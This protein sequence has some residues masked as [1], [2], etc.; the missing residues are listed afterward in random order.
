[1]SINPQSSDINAV[2][3]S[4]SQPSFSQRQE[5]SQEPEWNVNSLDDFFPACYYHKPLSKVH[6]LPK[7]SLMHYSK[8]ENS[9]S[10]VSIA[11]SN[12]PLLPIKKPKV[13][14]IS[15]C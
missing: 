4:D 7:S 5:Y 13:P 15:K 10:F 8:K 3:I 11:Q 1:M 6:F 14:H 2:N 12:C 9:P